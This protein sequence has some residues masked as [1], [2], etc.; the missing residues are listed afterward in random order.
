MAARLLS[1]GRHLIVADRDP[2]TLRPFL[3]LGAEAVASPRDMAD[4]AEVIFACLPSREASRMVALGEDGIVHGKAVRVYVE[5]STVGQATI[6]A[7]E[8]GFSSKGISLL[9]MPVSGGPPWAREGRLTA[10]LAGPPEAREIVSP[11]LAD[12]AQKVVV[13]GDRP[14]LAQVAKLVNNM[15]SFAGM[16]AACEAIVLGVRAG[17]DART[18]LDVVNAGSG[19]NSATSDKFPRA[20]LPRTFDY[21]GP[22]SLGVKDIE[23][24][25]DI[26]RS[27]GMPTTLGDMVGTLWRAAVESGRPGQDYS[28][29]VRHFE[30]MAGVE[31]KG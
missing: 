18:L 13:V 30:R 10:I 19:R 17:L 24:Y 27:V 25:R 31:V 29:I 28:E 2:V 21:G 5:A 15:I 3:D 12:L 4:R 23:L 6:A 20:I 26:G 7:I 22:L 8:E 11:V 14:G 16:V 1:Q 9:D